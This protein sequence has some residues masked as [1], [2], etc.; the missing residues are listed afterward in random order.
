MLLG[1]HLS[2]RAGL[3]DAARQAKRLG[4]R[5]LQIFGYRRHEFY[6]DPNLTPE[7]RRDLEEEFG[8]WKKAKQEAGIEA[9]S[10]HSRAVALL[11]LQDQSHRQKALE[12][13]R[14]EIQLAHRL[15]ARWYVFHLGPY[16]AGSSLQ[17]GLDSAGGALEEILEGLPQGAPTL[18]LENVP[19]GG[20]R[21]GSSLEEL[22]VLAKRLEFFGARFGFCLDFAH[23]WGAGYH[24]AGAREAKEFIARFTQAVGADKLALLHWNNSSLELGCRKDEHTHLE[25]GHIRAEVY[26]EALHHWPAQAGFL[27]TPKEPPGSDERNLAFLKKLKD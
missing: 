18:V 7:K 27:E 19:G 14:Q 1:A 23:L 9:V 8:L 25:S 15:E 2:V 22:G 26:A 16:E 10:V 4:L 20:R 24:L 11:A 17:Q 3:V 12:Q 13:F 5:A 21:M 6:F